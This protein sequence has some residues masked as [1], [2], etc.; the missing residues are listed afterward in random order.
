M[1]RE[2]EWLPVGPASRLSRRSANVLYKLAAEGAIRTREGPPVLFAVAD[3]KR[4]RR[5]P[6]TPAVASAD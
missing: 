5:T 3:L 2:A 4:L 1:E 6:Q